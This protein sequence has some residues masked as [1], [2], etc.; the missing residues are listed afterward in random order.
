MG[1]LWDGST[2][3][4]EGSRTKRCWDMRGKRIGGIEEREVEGGII[5]G[6]EDVFLT[7]IIVNIGGHIHI[8]YS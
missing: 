6:Q 4:K 5:L 1:G 8:I 3:S 7:D 2:R